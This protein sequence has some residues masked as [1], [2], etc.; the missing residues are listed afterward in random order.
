MR[1]YIS[2]WIF[3]FICMN[4]WIYMCN[5]EYKRATMWAIVSLDVCN[6]VCH[7][8]VYVIFYLFIS[9]CVSLCHF[10]Y[11]SFCICKSV[12]SIKTSI[13]RLYHCVIVC[14]FFFLFLRDSVYIYFIFIIYI[15]YIYIIINIVFSDFSLSFLYVSF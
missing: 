10:A 1:I 13:L 7:F 12:S 3:T 5:F 9:L 14:L 8:C 4:V 6:C 2:I 11:V 15:N